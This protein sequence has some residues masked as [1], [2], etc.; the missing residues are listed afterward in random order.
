MLSGMLFVLVALVAGGGALALLGWLL[1]R[2]NRGEAAGSILSAHA[3]VI[4][5]REVT[6]DGGTQHWVEFRLA[7][8]NQRELLTT[9]SQ[10]EVIWRG[11]SGTV[12]WAGDR[13]TGWVPE[14]GAAP[15][16]VHRSE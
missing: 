2:G 13:L 10:A 14:L 9:A 3:Q 12:H 6:S 1:A 8:G 5:K 4:A 7:D 15:R 11:Q 16:D